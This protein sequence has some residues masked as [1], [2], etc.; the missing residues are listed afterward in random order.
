MD[1]DAVR[2]AM[3]HQDPHPAHRGFAEAIG[4]DLVDYHRLSLGPLEGT[5]LEDGLNGLAFPDYDVYLVE[6]SRPLY[7]A[8]ARRVARGGTLVY[9]CADH[10]LYQLGSSGFE[11]ESALKS[12]IG[13][14]GSPAARI[15]GRRGIDGVVA[16]SE[17]AAEFTRPVVGPN[18]PIEVA[19]PFIQPETYNALGDVR[20]DLEANVAVTVARPWEYKGVDVLVDA[21]PRVRESIPDAELHVVGG[22]H[23]A[24]YAETPGVRVRGYV[25]DL[26]DAF[27]PASLFVQPSRMDTFPVSTL[28][29]MRAGLVPLVTRTAGTRSEAREIDPSLVVAPYERALARGVSAYFERSG[30]DRRKLADRARDRGARF[31]PDSRKAAFRSAFRGVLKAL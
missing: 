19:H 28:E 22:G 9:L 23:P 13:T 16:V 20:P 17:F 4:A 15:A 11:G 30:A 10:G 7:A 2:V 25:E 26:A 24:E 5:I 12:L 27:A 18:T 8:L 14:F 3:L 1:P 31:D 21:W 29:A 6:G